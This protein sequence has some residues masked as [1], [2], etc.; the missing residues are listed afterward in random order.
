[1]STLKQQ[2]LEVL[3]HNLLNTEEELGLSQAAYVSARLRLLKYIH[4]GGCPRDLGGSCPMGWE[5]GKDQS[6]AP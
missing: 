3:E 6:C 4:V 2:A 5:T 1:M